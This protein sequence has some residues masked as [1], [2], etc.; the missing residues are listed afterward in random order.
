MRTACGTK[1]TKVQDFSGEAKPVVS[2]A[3]ASCIAGVGFEIKAWPR[4]CHHLR[5]ARAVLRHPHT[6]V[7]R[8]E[9]GD[10][11][12]GKCLVSVAD[13]AQAINVV[14]GGHEDDVV[15]KI[16]WL[17]FEFFLYHILDFLSKL[18]SRCDLGKSSTRT[19]PD[20]R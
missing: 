16:V 12:V 18:Q 1:T 2:V 7:I 17:D 19:P 13:N 11:R 20:R 5:F 9:H 14:V 15:L 4:R 8:R 6:V 10:R 3:E